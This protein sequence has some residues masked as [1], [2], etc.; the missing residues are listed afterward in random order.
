MGQLIRPCQTHKPENLSSNLQNP[1]EKLEAAVRACNP[2]AEKADKQDP[3]ILLL[4]PAESVNSG[5]V[6]DCF[7][8]LKWKATEKRSQH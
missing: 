2:G 8:K 6:R 5:P 7:K 4:S 1:G 3:W